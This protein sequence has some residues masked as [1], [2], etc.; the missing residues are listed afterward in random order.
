VPSLIAL[1]DRPKDP[2]PAI[3][4]LVAQA[5][6]APAEARMRLAPEPP[7]LILRQEDAIAAALAEALTKAGA[8]A[9]AVDLEKR[10]ASVLARSFELG[11]GQVTF[12]GRTGDET[13]LGYGE[14]R[15][16][17]RG[18]RMTS[19][20]VVKT[21]TTRKFDIG[22]AIMTQGLMVTKTHKREVRSEVK[23]AYHAA[24][25]YGRE[26]SV[27]LDEAELTYQ[28]LG[29][30][31]KPSRVENLNLLVGEL[32][33]RAT[34]ARYDDRLLRMG[35]RPLPLEPSDPFDVIAEILN[36]AQLRGRLP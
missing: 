6:L 17:L 15:L 7:A 34:T 33:K 13:E 35:S 28:S 24:M 31:L 9:L 4:L 18:L 19:S 30:A 26:T 11:P 20:E 8:P 29:P 22:K 2:G 10:Q 5:G 1:I 3:A 27:L 16:I 32:R 23:N 25:L 21:E 12:F 36:Q 14:I